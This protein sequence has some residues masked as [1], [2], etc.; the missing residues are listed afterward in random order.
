VTVPVLIGGLALVAV[1]AIAGY[2]RLALLRRRAQDAGARLKGDL[3]RRH[4]L[5]Q[6]LIQASRALGQPHAERLDSVAAA[7]QQATEAIG[8]PAREEAENELT[9]ALHALFAAAGA[10]PGFWAAP[11]RQSM[12][13]ELRQNENQILAA[14][15]CY[16]QQV[17]AVN[18]T[19]ARLPFRCIA[20]L[21]GFRPIE[22]FVLNEPPVPGAPCDG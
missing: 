14:G 22:Y 9:W 4:D 7:R 5:V 20:R 18:V 21:A 17:M 2:A 16:N 3:Q 6:S 8:I 10:D 13:E 15:R 19:M 11:G 12:Q 1:S